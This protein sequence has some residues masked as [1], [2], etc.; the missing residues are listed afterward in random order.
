MSLTSQI[1]KVFEAV[2][3]DEIVKFL[4]KYKLI[5]D[6]QHGFRKGRSCVT[7]LLL[8][9]DRIL[10]CVDEG[11]C[12]DIVFFTARRNARIASA[13]LAT[14]IP[15]VCPSVCHTPVLCQNNST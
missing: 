12:V 4:D 6:S 3:R 13:V 14:A 9:L 1:C 2:V 15:S 5:R 8:F 7:N 11:F 10:R